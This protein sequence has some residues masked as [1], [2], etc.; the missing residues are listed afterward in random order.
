MERLSIDFMIGKLPSS[1]GYS[2]IL[3]VINKFTRLPFAFP[4]KDRTTSSV[5]FLLFLSGAPIR[6]RHSG[7]AVSNF[8]YS[9]YPYLTLQPLAC[10]L[11]PH[12]WTS[13]LVFLFSF[14]LASSKH[15]IL[16]PLYSAFRLCTCPYYL[17][18]A[19]LTLSPICLTWAVP[20]INSFLTLSILVTPK[21]N[22]N[23]FNSATASSASCFLVNG[24]ISKPYSMAGL[25]TVL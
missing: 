15:N 7:S 21:E 22:L 14:Y 2:D 12:P 6:G 8:S 11:L 25:T 1:A 23:I 9:L 3:T 16:L 18:L 5:L 19:S 20:R 24:I 10:P 17:N 13:S 4:T